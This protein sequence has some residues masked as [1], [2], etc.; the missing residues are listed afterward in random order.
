MWRQGTLQASPHRVAALATCRA[1]DNVKGLRSFIGA[2]KVLAR[3]IPKCA[4]VIAPLENAIAGQESNSAVTWTDEL[5]ES[6]SR[7]QKAVTSHQ[8]IHLPRPT[9][10]LWIVTDGAVKEPGIG[11]TL[12]ISRNNRSFIAGF[13]SAKLRGRQMSWIPC[14]IEALAIAVATKHFSPYIIQSVHK[15]CILTDSRP[16]VMAF[17]KLCR[18]EFSASPRVSTFLS[19]V[20]RY[21]MSVQH[22]AGSAILP[23]DFA[24]RNAPYCE[25]PTCQICSFVSK[26][27]DCVVRGVT[28]QDIISGKASLP[29]TSKAAW[30]AIQSECSDLRRTHAHLKQGT[31]PSKKL[32]D[33]KDVK[34]YL[35]VATIA[36]DG[37]LVVKHNEPFE[38]TKDCII[39]PRQVLHGFITSL[40]L[41]LH[42][43]SCHQLK[44]MMK[45]YFFALDLDKAIED[46]T[47]GCHHCAALKKI[48]NTAIEQSSEDPPEKVGVT[49][50]ADVMR[51]ERQ[52]ILV[53]REC[54][55]SFTTATLVDNECHETIRSA[56]IALC[57]GL[58][59]LD[60]PF[61]VIRTD[62]APCFQ[63]LTNDQLLKSHRL[64]IE[65]GRT[66]NINK[67]PVA[68]KA[69]QELQ[70]EIL[71]HDPGNRTVSSLSLTSAVASLNSRIRSNGLS[72]REMLLQ[73][74]QFTNSQIPISD[75][76]VIIDKH[77]RREQNHDYSEKSKAP[78]G[79]TVKSPALD[80]GDL[81]YLYSDRNKTR[82]RD[83]YLVVSTEP[84]WCNI[85]KFTGNQ[86]RNMSYR[87]KKSECYK[88]PP[89]A[90]DPVHAA[91][92]E[93]SRDDCADDDILFNEPPPVPDIP[94]EI[95]TQCEDIGSTPPLPESN[96]TPISPLPCSESVS[97][98]VPNSPTPSRPK[99]NVRLPS[100]F[101]DFVM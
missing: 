42:H 85:R 29:F 40:H 51:R 7:A 79:S 84:T 4:T 44:I 100:R 75:R 70:D 97:S 81:V 52:C 23:S 99:R 67:N 48:P 76:D 96:S 101:D 13:F 94:S 68:E 41:R 43:P 77:L 39:I 90:R 9:D 87:V 28:A 73:R 83:R 64:T 37:L 30:L 65:I 95:K 56:L 59:P 91:P 93:T 38:D 12:Y 27:E 46:M 82:A 86:L 50:A 78:K 3:V 89:F 74:D 14:E 19:M 49:F 20:S 61:A 26:T 17:E 11:A 10:Q 15:A 18:G 58:R 8:S 55:T 92:E 24:S 36:K 45:R 22:V 32:T 47:N 54:T 31:R 1:P 57:I 63:A 72:S 34:R 53:V 80:V 71:R 62:P 16:C 98:S 60:G 69:V 33:V 66:K 5:V 35:R 25:E 21:Q 88:V 2:V 6:F